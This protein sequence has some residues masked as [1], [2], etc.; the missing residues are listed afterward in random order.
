MSEIQSLID[1]IAGRSTAEGF[2]PKAL[3]QFAALPDNWHAESLERFQ[4]TPN[5]VDARPTFR[6]TASLVGYVN[7]FADPTI[8][9]L[10]SSATARTITATLDHHKTDGT[11]GWAA[12]TPSFAAQFDARFDAWRQIN[13]RPLSQIKA[14]QFLEERA[15]DVIEPDAAT[16]MDMVMQFDA[17]KKVTFKQ[18]TRLHDGQRQFQYIEENEA[19]GAVTLPEKIKLRLPIFDGMEPDVF[20]VRLR[21]RIDDGSLNFSFEIH[22]QAEVEDVAFQR[23]EDAV[24]TGVAESIPLYRMI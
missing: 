6:D 9:V 15:V 4:D 1:L 14:G 19:R 17:L 24:R 5:R 2:R 12:W 23:C 10:T 7:R 13:G 20:M 16:I 11:P 18:S 8:A 3:G 22:D 21:F